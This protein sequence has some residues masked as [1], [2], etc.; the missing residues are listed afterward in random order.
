MAVW[1]QLAQLGPPAL[2]N[3]NLSVP[4]PL[5]GGTRNLI[6]DLLATLSE[7][8]GLGIA[9]PQVYENLRIVVLASRPTPR[10]PSLI[11]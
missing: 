3:A 2:R 5:D 6:V 10:D 8:G 7:S 11:L 4:F 9:A 1:R